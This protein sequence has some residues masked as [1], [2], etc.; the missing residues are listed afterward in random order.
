VS[1]FLRN[2]PPHLRR[3]AGPEARH[4]VE[5][6]VRFLPELLAVAV[7]I[8]DRHALRIEAEWNGR[9]PLHRRVLRGPVVRGGHERLDRAVGRGIEAF[10]RL[11]DLAAGID[12]D[13][14]AAAAHFVDDA[15]EPLRGTLQHV[16][17][18][19]PGGGKPPMDPRLGDHARCSE[20]RRSGNR[21]RARL[22]KKR[23]PFGGHAAS[24]SAARP[25]PLARS[26]DRPR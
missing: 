20:R 3:E 4:Q 1:I 18:R 24:P 21:R 14:E 15:R 26:N 13:A 23:S 9:E 5:L 10:E 22:R 7:V 2:H 17:L 19:R 25:G 6:R 8:P 16:E 11:H 12:V